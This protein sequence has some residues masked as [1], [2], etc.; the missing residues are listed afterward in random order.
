MPILFLYFN[1]L[2]L[3]FPINFTP[4]VCGHTVCVVEVAL[5][6]LLCKKEHDHCFHLA[7]SSF[8]SNP[9]QYV[10]KKVNVFLL[11]DLVRF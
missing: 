7:F 9:I 1:F 11:D 3:I 5:F 4:K 10:I 2:N 6:D 8:S